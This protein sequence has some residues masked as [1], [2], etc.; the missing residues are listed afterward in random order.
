MQPQNWFF[1]NPFPFV[2]QMSQIKFYTTQFNS[3]I[4]CYF[5]G[6]GEN[7]IDFVF[8]LLFSIVC[9][10]TKKTIYRLEQFLWKGSSSSTFQL[11]FHN[12]FASFYKIFNEQLF[13]G[14]KQFSPYSTRNIVHLSLFC[15]CKMPFKTLF[16]L[17]LAHHV[18]RNVVQTDVLQFKQMRKRCV[19]VI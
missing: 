10:S 4:I 17:F 5:T 11:S 6:R 9:Y 3:R 2:V 16:Y 1:L 13:T 19:E 8:I 7:E 18:K 14:K 12:L 15:S